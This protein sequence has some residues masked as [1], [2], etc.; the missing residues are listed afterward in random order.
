VRIPDAVLKSVGFIGELTSDGGTEVY[1]DLHATGFFVS[2]PSEFPGDI[3]DRYAFFVTAKH[4]A[5]DLK[6]REIYFLVNKKGGGV[7]HLTGNG[8]PWFLHPTD[9][10]ADVAIISV[11]VDPQAD[12][13]G[14]MVEDFVSAD[15][16]ANLQGPSSQR[17][18]VGDEVFATG[19]FTP[20]SGSSRILPIVRHG[21]IAML[22][23]EQIQTELGYA[24]VYLV[25]ARSIGG[26][27]GS[28]V[29]V[30]PNMQMVVQHDGIL[31]PANL[32]GPGK[33]LGLMHGHWDIKECEKNDPEIVH[34]RKHGVNLGIG[35]VVP[36]SK[37]RETMYQPVLVELRR[38]LEKMLKNQSVPGMDSAKPKDKE[39]EQVVFTK[40]DF[41]VALKK[42]SRK[43]PSSR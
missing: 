13:M 34:D 18:G 33:F 28:P 12:I 29:W 43:I 20:A 30:R 21:N 4:V 32:V 3:L 40:E 27:S 9:K 15:D 6:D 37:I 23:S 10:T 31:K 35:I 17:V 22:P 7:M 5:S 8:R 36:A 1:G 2:I 39:S 19:L 42:A 24:D 16:L 11:D 41:E 38:E 26:L 14:I 25:E